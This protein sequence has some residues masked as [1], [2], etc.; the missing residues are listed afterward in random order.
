MSP[1]RRGIHIKKDGYQYVFI[2]VTYV[3][4]DFRQMAVDFSCACFEK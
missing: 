1:P 4:F 3:I 2:Y